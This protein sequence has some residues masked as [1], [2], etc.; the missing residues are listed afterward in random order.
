MDSRFHTLA[1]LES[2][3][4]D[5]ILN[6][7][8]LGIS[9]LGDLLAYQPFRQARFVR[10]AKDRLLTKDVIAPYLDDT[11]QPQDLTTILNSPPDALKGVDGA[12]AVTLLKLGIS[13]IEGLARYAPFN[14]AE[15]IVTRAVSDNSDPFAPPCVLPTCRK[16]TRSSKSYV[17][18]FKQEEIRDLSVLTLR[19][20]RYSLIS[21]LFH[22]SGNQSHVIHLGY[23][24]SY[25]QEW[26]YGGVHLGEP[27]G[28]VNLFMGQDTQVSVLDWRRAI[29]ALRTEDTKVSERLTSTLFHQRAV[30]EVARATA[31][32]H[33]HGGTSAF[34][35]NAATAGS[36]VAAGALVGGVGG[37]ISGALVGLSVDALTGG[38]TAG[39]GTLSGAVV[40]TAVGS[41][42]GAAAGSLIVA[43]A[44][45]LGFVETDA[46]GD[47]EIFAR[48][49]QN[50]Q[51]RTIQNSSSLRSFW[52][53]IISQSVQEDQQRIRTDR[54]TNHN[55]I[56]ALNAIF[57]EVLNEYRVNITAND[58]SAILFLPFKPIQF[59][60]EILRRYWWLIRTVVTDKA[61]VASLDTYFLT[62]SSD[63]SPGDSADLPRIGDIVTTSV[64]VE[65][66]LDGSVMEDIIKTLVGAA[67]FGAALSAFRALFDA[68]KR[69][70]IKVSVIASG[71][72][73][74]LNRDGSANTDPNFVGRYSANIAVPVH[75]IESIKIENTNGEFSILN[76]DL[77]E[78]AFDG[79]SAEIGIKNINNFTQALPNIGALD[80]KQE[81]V[82]ETFK[83]GAEKSKT[84]PWN[85][86]DQLRSQFEGVDAER[87]DLE[88]DAADAAL[89][90]AR[91]NNLVGFLNANK[92]GFTRFILENTEREQVTTVLEE[93]QVGGV[94]L[95]SIAGTTPLGFCGNHVVLPLKKCSRSDEKY[96]P[97]GLDTTVLEA[98][99]ARLNDVDTK[100]PAEVVQYLAA[101]RAFLDDFLAGASSQ[102]NHSARERQL[103]HRVQALKVL[104]DRIPTT[105]ASDFTSGSSRKARIPAGA[106]A[107]F[108]SRLSAAIRDLLEFLNASVQTNDPDASRLCGYYESVK[109]S[110]AG[111]LGQIVSSDEVS[112]PSPAVFMEPVLSN[113][114]GAELYDMRRNS[115]Y[116]ILP[117]P[118]I[119]AADPNVIRS[120]DIQL[121]PNVPAPSLTIQAAPT[122]AL[123]DSITTALGQAGKLDLSTLINTNAGTLNTTLTNLSSV[124]SELAKA[125]AQLTGDAQKQALASAGEVA[126]QVGDFIGKTLQT[127]SAAPVAP[128]AP[129]PDPPEGQQSKAEVERE[130][131]RINQGPG[132]E[133]TKTEKKETIGAP[134]SPDDTREYQMSIVFIDENRIPYKQGEFTLEMTF[135]EFASAFPINAGGPIQMSNGQFLFKDKIKLKKGRK[136]TIRI[137]ADIL[138]AAIPGLTDFVLPDREDILFKCKMLSEK[139]RVSQTNVK[140][141]VDEAIR[142]SSFGVALNPI[143][144]LFLNGGVKFPFEIFEVNAGG[145]GSTKLD[146][147]AEYNA[148]SSSSSGSTTGSTTV[149]EF[150]V[151]VPLNGWEIE[152]V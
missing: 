133:K 27:Q 135:F 115:H 108:I 21:D 124:A 121:T 70:N 30:D 56:H 6:L 110:L 147:K 136:A 71:G 132:T 46:E 90:A 49:A 44:T 62:L 87:A 51:Q 127:Q 18:F 84:V 66:N 20:S 43:G 150:E 122:F 102:G 68:S 47:R 45:T 2:L 57:F 93:V 123:P 24:V 65:L 36:F 143:F 3:S 60:E 42:A 7:R 75:T 111:R 38:A 94:D 74:L 41:V 78:L 137:D 114:K 149:R 63:P 52:S 152:V 96:D 11:V 130:L 142:T 107:V 138:G 82:S 50:I 76:F 40:G 26:I 19:Q 146:L 119:A 99:L 131:D 58:F 88:T 9:N 92:F 144:D 28:S 39:L 118:A 139:Q 35:A 17:S 113:A 126:K 109:A 120:Q 64:S 67:L 77:S 13:T 134:V 117:A 8:K 103:L 128:P 61:L 69:D 91:I 4:D 89:T 125:S 95:S 101:L 54:V 141:A 85:I 100:S 145:G 25:L 104:V 148:S 97:I 105:L 5:N 33:Q 80:D 98:M 140:S 34:G 59:T 81:V 16:F 72:T 48:S 151:V 112:L 14:E 73:H 106:L 29:T 31:E 83:I 86:A 79:V 32:E 23:S 129:K 55:R 116:E 12:A 15:E 37:G 22:F 53:N 1:T 10:A